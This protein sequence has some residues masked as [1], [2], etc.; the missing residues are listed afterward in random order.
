MPSCDRRFIYLLSVAHRRVSQ[1][2]RAEKGELTASQAGAL[3]VIGRE[4]GA[5]VGDVARALDVGLPGA[6]GLVDRMEAAGLLERRPDPRDG[7]SSR[8][9]L[10]ARGRAARVRAVAAAAEINARLVKGFTEGELDTVARWLTEVGKR[11]AKE[12]DT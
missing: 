10:T 11:F 6:S 2:A 3:F 7:R 4:D 12:E 8:L 1:W 9:F 5:L